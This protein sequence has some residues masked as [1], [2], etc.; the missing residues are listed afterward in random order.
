MMG[1]K[2]MTKLTA[3][4]CIVT[5]LFMSGAN[6]DKFELRGAS[7]KGVLRFWWR[8]LAYG[9]FHGDLQQIHKEEN[10]IF[11]SADTGRGVFILR[12]SQP[13]PANVIEANQILKDAN[14]NVLGDG[15]I[16]L[17]YGLMHSNPN[18]EKGTVKGQ[19]L[20]PYLL[21]PSRFIVDLLFRDSVD[22][23][24]VD[25]LKLLGLIG[26]LG[27]RSRR[28]FG[29][30][31][32]EKM[33]GDIKWTAPLDVVSYRSEISS[34]LGSLAQGMPEYTALTTNSRITLLDTG[35]DALSLLDIIGK[36][37]QLYRSWGNH[38]KV[39][40]VNSEKNFYQ[41]H[42]LAY[43]VANGVIPP[44]HPQRVVFGLPHNYYLSSS[45]LTPKQKKFDVVPDQ[46]TRRASPFM[47]HIHRFS[48]NSFAGVACILPARF[49][50]AGEKIKVKN[51]L[52]LQ[53]ID[54]KFLHDFLDGY[55]G[56]AGEKDHKRPYFPGKTEVY[57]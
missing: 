48:D 9:R 19:L 45:G 33:E 32:L 34:L 6:Q 56:Q 55:E 54:F 22:E 49:L 36:K 43:D 41:D 47:I 11:G 39:G 53:N 4:F 37:M 29:S 31:T 16:Y 12:I 25:A 3:T 24:V 38:G 2:K 57:P 17:G 26:G 51:N 20:R 46:N 35:N 21:G 5:P 50:P 52:V 42:A 44:T 1:E 10:H 13:M 30:V 18:R 23:S 28:G 7:F 14:D 27:S 40:Q 8:A 15:G